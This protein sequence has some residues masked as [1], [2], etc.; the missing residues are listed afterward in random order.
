MNWNK[1]IRNKCK[2]CKG[3]TKCFKKENESGCEPL[4]ITQKSS[5]NQKHGKDVGRHILLH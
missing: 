1:C 3:Y 4:K 2:A 5:I